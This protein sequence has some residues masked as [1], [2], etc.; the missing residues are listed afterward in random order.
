MTSL[1]IKDIS[2]IMKHIDICMMTTLKADGTMESRPMSNNR[3]V[4]Y[5]G[6]SY[7]F[8]YDSSSVAQELMN[9]P[10]VN[11]SFIGHHSLLNRSSVYIT[12]E[13]KGTLIRD[14]ATFLEHWVKDLDLW[15][16]QGADTPGLVLIKVH[17]HHISYWDGMEHG[18][19]T[20]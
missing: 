12:V 8:T 18:E 16:K 20:L 4:D 11:L 5:T 3:E 6:D 19:V 17:A 13:G 14:K 9:K 2:D 15:F 7:Y 10:D 1:T